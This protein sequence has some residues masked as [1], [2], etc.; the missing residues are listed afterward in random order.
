MDASKWGL[1]VEKLVKQTCNEEIEWCQQGLLDIIHEKSFT[2]VITSPNLASNWTIQITWH[3]AMDQSVHNKEGAI[4][5]IFYIGLIEDPWQVPYS[6]EALANAIDD[7]ITSL[8]ES[9]RDN[10]LEE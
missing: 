2:T 1:F 5:T 9:I 8:A 4:I 10:F 7:S 3:P 6:G